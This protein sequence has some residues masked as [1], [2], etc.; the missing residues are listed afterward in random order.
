VGELPEPSGEGWAGSVETSRFMWIQLRLEGG[1][2]A[3]ARFGTYGCAPAIAAGSF[4]TEWVQGRTVEEA[5]TASA[6]RLCRALGGLPEHRRFC[7]DMAVDALHAALQDALAHP[8]T[9]PN[10]QAGAPS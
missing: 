8:S 7:A 3:E 9:A 6:R 4:L 2:V 10:E 5:F 1:R